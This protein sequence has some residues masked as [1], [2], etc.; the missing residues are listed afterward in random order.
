MS[1]ATINGGIEQI[2]NNVITL[3]LL[4][5]LYYQIGY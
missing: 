2:N 4:F 5:I 1:A 3:N